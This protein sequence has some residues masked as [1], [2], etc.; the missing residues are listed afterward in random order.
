MKN[1]IY[2]SY[3]GDQDGVDFTFE[4][5]GLE[6]SVTI[7]WQWGSSTSQFKLRGEDSLTAYSPIDYKD[8]IVVPANNNVQNPMILVAV[9][10]VKDWT[11]KLISPSTYAMGSSNFHS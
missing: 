6:D 3:L 11:Q 9:S 2:R 7:Q 10:S 8:D 1:T 4:N 5:I